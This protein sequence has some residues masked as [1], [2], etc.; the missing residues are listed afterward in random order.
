[1]IDSTAIV[2]LNVKDDKTFLSAKFPF[3]VI[4]FVSFNLKSKFSSLDSSKHDRERF[5]EQAKLRLHF[6]LC[7]QRQS[8]PS[9][10]YTGY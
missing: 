1:M 10:F 4:H 9:S 7:I 8:I 6:F 2:L 5:I 3:S